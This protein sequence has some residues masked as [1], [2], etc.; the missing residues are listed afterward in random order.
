MSEY[1]ITG[2]KITE[3][4]NN[5]YPT[6]NSLFYVVQTGKQLSS[7]S[8]KYANLSSRIVADII[9]ALGLGSMAHEEKYLYSL[10]S[11][12]HDKIYSKVAIKDLYTDS[13]DKILSVANIT[14]QKNDEI[15]TY[16][17]VT[18]RIQTYKYAEVKVG[19]LKFVATNNNIWTLRQYNDGKYNI[20]V[21]D[22]EFDGWVFPNGGY[23]DPLS[24]TLPDLSRFVK[25][26]PT[27]SQRIQ[28][29][30]ALLKHDHDDVLT[31][32]NMLGTLDMYRCWVP[33][34][35]SCNT[36][37]RTAHNG[38]TEQSTT[39]HISVD[40]ADAVI[41]G[42]YT[43]PPM[44]EYMIETKPYHNLMPVMIYIGTENDWEGDQG[45]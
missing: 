9:D 12:N 36:N 44:A 22:E 15:S 39:A 14:I 16:S 28:Y 10:S 35:R 40:F 26:Q 29:K 25:L 27:A 17:I 24:V 42:R 41:R 38:G 1:E 34:T 21:D 43:E 19:T 31:S 7:E 32:L 2:Q 3:V 45:E 37:G 5:E 18:P 20:D 11:H 13:E 33:T 30:N 6:K 4:P 23:L 8:I